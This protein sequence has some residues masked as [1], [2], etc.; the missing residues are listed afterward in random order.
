MDMDSLFLETDLE[1]ERQPGNF[2]FH[3][4]TVH[5]CFSLVTLSANIDQTV[6]N[7]ET[8]YAEPS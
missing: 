7:I 4:L 6:L 5:L 1:A 3:G 8:E 2:F